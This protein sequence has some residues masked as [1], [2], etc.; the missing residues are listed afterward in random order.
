MSA[1]IL[2]KKQYYP[3]GPALLEYLRQGGRFLPAPLRYAD[4][5]RYE[6]SVPLRDGEDRE[7]L[8]ESVLYPSAE[9]DELFAQLKRVY[10]WLKTAGNFE[11]MQHL[12]VERVDY[13]SFGNSR[14][15]RVKIV[16]RYNDNHDYFYVKVPDA[17]RVYGLELEDVLSP[18]RISYLVDEHTLVEE[19]ITGIP[20]D[21]FAH[22]HLHRYK[23]TRIAKEFV[24]FN[25]RC[26]VRLLGDMRA[27]NFVVVATGDFDGT[28]FRIRAIDFDQQS[29]EG[30]KHVYLPHL[31]AENAPYVQLGMQLLNRETALQYQQEERALMGRRASASRRR[32]GA[33]L[34]VLSQ[35][36]LAPPEKLR[37]LR[38]ALARHYA[39]P[40]FL[41]CATMGELV[42]ES[43]RLLLPQA[44]R[45]QVLP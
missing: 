32:L 9:R 15:F 29:Y 1:F 45:A 18:N 10:A 11:V 31:F 27:Y 41:E 35:E 5:L 2:Q 42:K 17:S 13:C 12:Q 37:V 21:V 25:E 6:G 40:G 34:R 36:Q 38:E 7:T 19:H 43:L 39:H 44:E 14:P 33:L 22:G 24:K 26:F 8:W 3:L 20:G 4:L 30:A 16:N 23:G 28:Q